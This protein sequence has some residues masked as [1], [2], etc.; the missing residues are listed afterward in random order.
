KRKREIRLKALDELVDELLFRQQVRENKI[1]VTPE[2]VDRQVEQL[3]KVNNLT[4]KQFSEALKME[5][6]TVADLKKE[7]RNQL[8]RQKLIDVQMRNNPEMRAKVQVS[9]KD[10]DAYYQTHYL[11]STAKEKV[12]ASHI[13]FTIPPGAEPAEEKKIRERAQKVMD[14]LKKGSSFAD[15][16]KQSSDD[17]SGAMGGDLGWFRRGDMMAAFEKA[18]FGLKKGQQSDLVRTKLGFHIILVT[19]RAVEGP[20]KRESVQNE[21]RSKLY[22]EKFRL[23][24]VEWMKQLRRNSFVEYKL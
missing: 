6:R 20:Q 12:R 11:S 24:M 5:G 4:Q 8:E 16:A 21:I 13:L 22:R 19:D 1:T 10:I 15:M 3:I 7:F 9:E 2:E 23:T 17:P 18:A 14:Q